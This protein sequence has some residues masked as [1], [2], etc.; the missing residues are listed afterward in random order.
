MNFISHFID[1]TLCAF[2][3]AACCFDMQISVMTAAANHVGK[4]LTIRCNNPRFLQEF[5]L[6]FNGL[7]AQ[8][9]HAAVKTVLLQAVLLKECLHLAQPPIGAITGPLKRYPAACGNAG[10]CRDNKRLPQAIKC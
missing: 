6:G 9:V 1:I 3:V 4:L 2:C 10:F 7:A 5:T 8:I